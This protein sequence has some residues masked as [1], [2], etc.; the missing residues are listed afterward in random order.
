M[1]NEKIL[2]PIEDNLNGLI[3]VSSRS[4]NGEGHEYDSMCVLLNAHERLN[5]DT[6]VLFYNTS[7]KDKFGIFSTEDSSVRGP[8]CPNDGEEMQF[9]KEEY[10]DLE[11]FIVYLDKVAKE[12]EYIDF[13]LLDYERING[14]PDEVC[15]WSWQ[16]YEIEI[17]KVNDRRDILGKNTVVNEKPFLKHNF[18]QKGLSI[19]NVKEQP[20][21]R[22]GRLQRSENGWRYISIWEGIK[23]IEEKLNNYLR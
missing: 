23:D 7:K 20:H 10:F 8:M 5:R 12:V 22:F 1:Y 13:L 17:Y 3:V 19:A 6:D 15:A 18:G 16:D 21:C 11:Y 2:N 14:A 4:L 9:W